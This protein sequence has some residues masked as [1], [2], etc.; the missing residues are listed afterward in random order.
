MKCAFLALAFLLAIPLFAGVRP[1]DPPPLVDDH[2]P[3]AA[4]VYTCWLPE[5]RCC[6][7]K[8]LRDVAPAPLATAAVT[9]APALTI[10]SGVIGPVRTS[11]DWCTADAECHLARMFDRANEEAACT[12]HCGPYEREVIATALYRLYEIEV[13]KYQHH[14]AL[15]RDRA[16]DLVKQAE[17]EI[18]NGR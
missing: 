7:G 13:R 2:T 4:Q 16:D 3:G 15:T 18:R 10:D 1:I 8:C 11:Y 5:A 9:E 14:G 17:G 6:P 12:Y